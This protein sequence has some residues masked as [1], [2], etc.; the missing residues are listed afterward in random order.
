MKKRLAVF[1]IVASVLFV[2]TLSAS[3]AEEPR[4]QVAAA[5]VFTIS[6]EVVSVDLQ[7][8]SITLKGPLGGLVAADVAADVD[9]LSKYH[10]G[11]LVSASYYE[12]VAFAVKKKGD[13]R[14]LFEA[15]GA[16]KR[17]EPGARLRETNVE[18]RT[19]TVVSVDPAAHSLV[20]QGA[21]KTIYPIEVEQKEFY[22]KLKDLRA[23]DTIDVTQSNAVVTKLEH[24]AAGEEAKVTMKV[25]TLVIDN[26]EIVKA[27]QNVLLIRND[28]G[29]MIRVQVPGDFHFNINGKL[30]SVYDLK[31]GTKLTRTAIR[32]SEVSYSK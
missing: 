30:M 23:G 18:T 32:V 4:S 3:F 5:T 25:G 15:T 28:K 26:G 24:L 6:A 29:R 11:D 7:Q 12:A 27:N 10:A 2:A 8:R 20:L 19:V 17:N 22:N 16:A 14:P 31:E 21:D 13:A 1:G 9:S